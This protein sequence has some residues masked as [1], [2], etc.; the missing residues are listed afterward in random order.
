MSFDSIK[1]VQK[2]GFYLFE[3]LLIIGIYT[4]NNQLE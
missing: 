1:E 2:G 4:S 3:L